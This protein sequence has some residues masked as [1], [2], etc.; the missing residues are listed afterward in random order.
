MLPPLHPLY[1][2]VPIS[3]LPLFREHIPYTQEENI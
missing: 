2:F 3:H 1:F